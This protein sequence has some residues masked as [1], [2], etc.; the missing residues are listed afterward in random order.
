MNASLTGGKDPGQEKPAAG[1]MLTEEQRPRKRLPSKE[2]HRSRAE[3]DLAEKERGNQRKD[4]GRGRKSA[5]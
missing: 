4:K 3:G 1:E 2:L 5:F